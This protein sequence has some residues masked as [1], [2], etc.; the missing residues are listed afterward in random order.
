[1]NSGY[2]KV[3]ENLKEEKKMRR[4]WGQNRRGRRITRKNKDN[5]F[6]ICYWD[7]NM[8][9]L[10]HGKSWLKESNQ[11]LFVKPWQVCSHV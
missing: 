11:A 6:L 5:V 9:S 4:V 10:V 7:A 2:L 3:R 8:K 1:M